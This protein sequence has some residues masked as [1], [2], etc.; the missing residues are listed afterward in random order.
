EHLDARER[1]VRHGV[2]AGVA[3]D[4]LRVQGVVDASAREATARVRDD[5]VAGCRRDE[6]VDD[7]HLWVSAERAGGWSRG[8]GREVEA[9]GE[10]TPVCERDAGRDGAELGAAWPGA[11]RRSAAWLGS[12]RRG[13]AWPSAVV[14]GAVG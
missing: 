8:P 11:A 12:A 7:V 9:G 10:L 4:I 1:G 3:D 14:C 5:P 2:G 6:I 13:A